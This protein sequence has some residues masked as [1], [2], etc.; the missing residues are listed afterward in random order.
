MFY[1][2]R[3]NTLKL[4]DTEMDYVTFGKGSKILIILP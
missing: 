1:G 3:E 2:A 4:E